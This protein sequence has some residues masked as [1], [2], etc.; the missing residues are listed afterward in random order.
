MDN[1]WTERKRNKA[2]CITV[3]V[4]PWEAQTLTGEGEDLFYLLGIKQGVAGTHTTFL[5]RLTL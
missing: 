1:H 4:P 3:H 5:Q 2:E